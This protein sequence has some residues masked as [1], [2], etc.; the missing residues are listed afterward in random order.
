MAFG[1]FEIYWNPMLCQLSYIP[2]VLIPN[3]LFLE[4]INIKTEFQFFQIFSLSYSEFLNSA[5]WTNN[6]QCAIHNPR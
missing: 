2:N 3:V 6:V 4:I 1:L 5:M